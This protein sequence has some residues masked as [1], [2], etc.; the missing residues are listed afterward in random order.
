MKGL[1]R[2]TV[3]YLPH[4]RL[5]EADL[6]DTLVQCSGPGERFTVGVPVRNVALDRLDELF[7]RS[8]ASPTPLVSPATLPRVPYHNEKQWDDIMY[9]LSDCNTLVA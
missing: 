7:E 9:I 3:E 8:E 5:A 6:G 4:F 2:I 1:P